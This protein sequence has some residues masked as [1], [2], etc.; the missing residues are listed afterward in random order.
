MKASQPDAGEVTVAEIGCGAGNAAFPL[1]SENQN[2]L[3]TIHAF[4]YSGHAVKLV[5]RNP[6][7]ENPPI[8]SIRAA[9]WDLT[10]PSLPPGV[11]EGSV[12]IVLLVFVLSALHP[13]EWGQ[14]V[15]NIRRMLKPGGKVFVRDYGRYDLT[16]L[17]F[18]SNRL[19][20]DN[21]YIRGDK[22]RVYFFELDELS[23]LFTGRAATSEEKTEHTS[24][25]ES[26]LD[27]ATPSAD[28][29]STVTPSNE[30]ISVDDTAPLV[31]PSVEPKTRAS[32]PPVLHPNLVN[33]LEVPE[34]PAHPLFSIEALHVDRR[35]LVNRKRQL[36]MYRVWMQG[37][38][39]RL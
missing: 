37:V 20:S 7:Y 23:L 39:V 35:L 25:E 33:G 21:F 16:Q 15:S 1:L 31:P 17:R 12:G 30:G 32:V 36:K 26:D 34:C 3:L 9:K 18:K 28:P 29:I 27:S 6:L 4:D 11:E 10:S 14:A 19:L 13:N 24:V 5:Q 2:P 38:F 8:G 22:T